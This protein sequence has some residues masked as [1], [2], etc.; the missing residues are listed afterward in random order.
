M[1]LNTNGNSL[2]V[3]I[4]N[5][6]G[7][8]VTVSGDFPTMKISMNNNSG[9][10]TVADLIAAVHA[11]PEA[12]RLVQVSSGAG[13]G[14][15]LADALVET[16]LAGG[17]D[18]ATNDYAEL[19]DENGDNKF[20]SLNIVKSDRKRYNAPPEDTEWLRLDYKC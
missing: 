4:I 5:A 6:A 13:D 11:D 9:A 19:L 15:G 18:D 8:G 2:S 7:L 10:A 16:N 17:L 20:I 14:T 12:R 3:E 1:V